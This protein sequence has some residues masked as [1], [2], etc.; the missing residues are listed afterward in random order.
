MRWAREED[1]EAKYIVNDYGMET[2]PE[3]W[4]IRHKDGHHV[5]A[6]SQR[7]RFIALFRRLADEGACPDGLGMQAHTG[8]W[9]DPASQNAI[10]D[11]FA[12][13]GVPLHY[14]EFWAHEHDLI[15][16]GVD[17]KTAAALKAEYVA[18]VMTVAFAHPAVESFYFWG[19]ITGSFG[20]R[21]DHNSSGLPTS[22]HEP[23]PTYWRVKDLLQKEWM[24]RTRL[25]TDGNG[26]GRFRGFLGDYTA[27]YFLGPSMAAGV[28]FSVDQQHEGIIRL[29]V[30]THAGAEKSRSD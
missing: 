27:R 6:Q 29:G 7:K 24:T 23:T 25:V 17:P 1:P 4:V 14:T 10:L 30:H 26:R 12:E 2:D 13:G 15:K 16:A 19:E 22:S 28:P 21:N 18:N 5:T 20:F 11:E 8:A 3:G 9:L